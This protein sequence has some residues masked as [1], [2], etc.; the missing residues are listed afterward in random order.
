MTA[1]AATATNPVAVVQR[2]LD[3]YNARDLARFLAEYAD[4]IEVYR[5]PTAA[6]AIVGKM[7]FGEFYATQRF[8]RADLHAEL[9]GRMAFGS[10]VIDHE[11][12]SGVRDQPFDVAVAYEVRDGLIVRTWAIAAE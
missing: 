6:P 12:I 4:D 9:R 11:R 10:K 5:L 3:A 7:A 1:G 8:N 2:Q